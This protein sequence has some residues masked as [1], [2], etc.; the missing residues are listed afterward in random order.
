MKLHLQHLKIFSRTS[1]P[2]ST[3]LSAKHPWMKGMGIQVCANEGPSFS[4]EKNDYVI[5]SL[6]IQNVNMD[7]LST[8]N[9]KL[10]DI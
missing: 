8:N 9:F 1:A 5:S 10:S 2:F 6:Y 7:F 4:K 3:K